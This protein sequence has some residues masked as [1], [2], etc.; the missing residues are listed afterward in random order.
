MSY[1]AI[2]EGDEATPAFLNAIFTE[3]DVVAA[4]GS[5]TLTDA[6]L[7][8]TDDGAAIGVSGTAWSDLFLASGA[9][10][11]FNAGDV[12]LTHEAN[13]L[14]TAGGDIHI[15]NSTGLVVGHTAQL[16]IGDRTAELQVLG[17]G[18]ADSSIALGRWSANAAASDLVLYKSRNAAIG[19]NT[20]VTTGDTLGNITSY[21]D[22]GTD[23]DT[24]SARIIF[25]TE[26]T[27]SAGQV[28]GLMSFQVAAAGTLADALTIDSTRNVSTIGVLLQATV[29][30]LANDA[31]PSVSAGNLF[32]TGGTTTI[33]DF[34]DGI[35]GQTIKILAAHSVTITDGAPIIL[36]GSAN[37]AMTDTDTLTLTMYNDQVWQEDSRSVN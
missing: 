35:V 16:S 14:S 21:G 27:I 23:D 1:T 3:L 4:G 9:V 20:A 15:S 29:T 28:P 11:N 25:G 5:L 32:K 33:T 17:T 24:V 19:S 18:T 30:T 13:K 34:D 12:T 10:I 6:L 36:N 2:V 26:G 37:Y 7:I 8:S 31:T 22:D